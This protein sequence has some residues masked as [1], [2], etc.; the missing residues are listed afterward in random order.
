MITVTWQ[1]VILAAS[2]L[3]SS[4]HWY[5]RGILHHGSDDRAHG[6]HDLPYVH[7]HAHEC[8]PYVYAHANVRGRAFML[9]IVAVLR[10]TM[11]VVMLVVMGVRVSM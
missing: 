6:Y 5:A 7:G 2:L 8:P 11:G 1:N 9:M 4:W 10:I 3:I